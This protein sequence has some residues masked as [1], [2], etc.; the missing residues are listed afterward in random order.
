[1][2]NNVQKL[3]E[4]RILSDVRQRLGADNEDDER[5]DKQINSMSNAEI[6]KHWA[7]WN[8]GD[9]SWW[10]SM[11]Y[12]FDEL[13]KM[14]YEDNKVTDFVLVF[15]DGTAS[16][17]KHNNIDILNNLYL[18]QD[19][20][21]EEGI[22]KKCVNVLLMN[23]NVD[24]SLKDT[25]QEIHNNEFYVKEVAEKVWNDIFN[26]DTLTYN[27]FEDYYKNLKI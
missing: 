15:D 6:V 1:M 26:N 17:T 7:G 18:N 10:T 22:L 2:K 8:L 20:R 21:T 23:K 16:I 27:T 3:K 13:N 25:W 4:L 24:E 14:K 11:K 19:V 12:Y 5:F 9:D